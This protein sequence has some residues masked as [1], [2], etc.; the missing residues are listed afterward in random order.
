MNVVANGTQAAVIG[1][2]HSLYSTTNN[3]MYVLMVDCNVLAL[4][5]VV[6]LSVDVA[7]SSG[8]SRRQT[9]FVSYAHAQGDQGKIS[10][11]VIAPYGAEFHLKQSSGTGRSFVWCVASL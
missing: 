4:G 10:V 1:T 11:P 9:Y 7:F 3:G 8:G 5:D 6:D 2:K